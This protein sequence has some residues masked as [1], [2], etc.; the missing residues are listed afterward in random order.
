MYKRILMKKFFILLPFLSY[1]LL[2]C[3]QDEKIVAEKE[4]KFLIDAASGSNN[5]SGR[6][7]ATEPKAVLVTI[8]DETGNT[9]ADSKVLELYKFGETFLSLPLTLKT[10]GTTHYRLTDF[11][12][13]DSDNNVLYATPKEG[14]EL[15]HLVA[16]ALDIEFAVTKDAITTVTPEVLA[17]DETNN[18]EDFGYGQFGFRVVNEIKVVFSSF[19]KGVNNFEI[20]DAHLKVEGLNIT[21]ADTVAQWIYETDLEAKANIVTLKEFTTYK[22]TASKLG[23]TTWSEIKPLAPQSKLEIIFEESIETADVYVAGYIHGKAAYWK[24]GTLVSLSNGTSGFSSATGIFVDNE[25]VYVT[26]SSGDELPLYWKNNELVELPVPAGTIRGETSDV[27]VVNQDLYVSGHYT[28]ATNWLPTYWKNGVRMD[29]QL[30]SL[31][32]NGH[33]D[34]IIVDGADVYAV[35]YVYASSIAYI[36]AALWKNGEF[37][38]LATPTNYPVSKAYG[39]QVFNGHVYVSGN[40]RATPTDYPSLRAV[41]WKDGVIELIEPTTQSVATALDIDDAGTIYIPYHTTNQ[42]GQQ[43]VNYWKNGEK[44]TLD[45]G[46][47]AFPYQLS[48]V[49]DEVYIVGTYRKG[50]YQID[51][52][53][54]SVWINGKRISLANEESQAVACFIVP[55]N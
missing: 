37:V 40:L 20:T 27:I 10:T 17:V 50:P 24:S 31:I 53:V 51:T 21:G 42:Q 41:Y 16:D 45:E 1:Y 12:V 52:A 35:G 15:A 2:S 36:T 18:P 22:I 47:F 14:S 55:K 26:Y 29:L 6:I 38:P 49:N 48:V 32:R 43:S 46:N 8:K 13:L 9:V 7:A 44:I 4:V 54:A 25:D 28:T 30:P 11:F 19:L 39:V 23:Y 5:S 33:V 3:H 34:K